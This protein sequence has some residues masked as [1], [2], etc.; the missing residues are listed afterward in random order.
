M[1]QVSCGDTSDGK[2]SK[3]W[4]RWRQMD[5]EHGCNGVLRGRLIDTF[6]LYSLFSSDQSDSIYFSIKT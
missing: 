5:K 1:K 3:A 4:A 2:I 6:A